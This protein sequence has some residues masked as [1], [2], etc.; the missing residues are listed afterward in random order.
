VFLLGRFAVAL[1]DRELQMSDAS[2]R[3]VALLA[4]RGAPIS[5][6][7]VSGLLWPE[8]DRAHAAARLR[9]SLYRVKRS[10]NQLILRAERSIQLSPQIT[11][12]YQSAASLGRKLC[13]PAYE[14]GTHELKAA[15]FELELLPGWYDNWVMGDRE[16]YQQL[17]FG[18]LEGIARR[19][20][21]LG[22]TEQAIQACLIV[23]R[24][25]P[26]RES[27]HRLLARAHAADGNHVQALQQLEQYV[28][29]A[30]R[31]MDAGPSALMV[32]LRNELLTTR[33][34]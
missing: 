20:L 34:F 27:A 33:R 28:D 14:P 25:E 1:G 30:D 32:D 10:S 13:E 16:A 12:D 6:E 17:R 15:T 31:E 26:L 18:A 9:T 22:L 21:G 4:L 7:L 2:Q 8:V 11:V 3:V 19:S 29:L 5:R 24:S 23:I